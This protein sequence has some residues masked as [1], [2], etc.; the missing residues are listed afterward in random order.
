MESI[1]N[2][3][4]IDWKIVLAQLFNFAVVFFI[5]Y[6]FAIKPVNKLM[7]ERTKKITQG[8]TDAKQNAE[9]VVAS[10]SEYDKALAKAR[11]EAQTIFQ[12][13]KKEAETKKAE[14]METAKKEVD[15]MIASGKKTLEAEKV[16]M[17]EDAKKEIV[18]LA[19]EAS[20]KILA[21]DLKDIDNLPKS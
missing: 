2:T 5:L 7:A 18:S 20:K 14:M 16:K 12:N 13:G 1:I 15:T 17:V 21:G 8:L 4:H 19:V 6:R 9:L 3:F 10:K 11:A